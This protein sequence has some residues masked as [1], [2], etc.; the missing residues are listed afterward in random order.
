M[1]EAVGCRC[2]TTRTGRDG[3]LVDLLLGEMAACRS[4]AACADPAR[5]AARPD[6]RS[7]PRRYSSDSPSTIGRIAAA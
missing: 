5:P 6:L 4:I 2:I 1:D 7:G 3:Q